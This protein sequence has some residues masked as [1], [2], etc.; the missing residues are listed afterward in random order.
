MKNASRVFKQLSD[1]YEFHRELRKH[2]KIPIDGKPEEK[3]PKRED[4][5]RLGSAAKRSSD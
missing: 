2:F 4:S 5:R 1:L 3:E